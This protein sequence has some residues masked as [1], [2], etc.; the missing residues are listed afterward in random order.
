M[1]AVKGRAAVL[2][3]RAPAVVT[4][5]TPEQVLQRKFNLFCTPPWAGRAGAETVLRLDP[6]RWTACDPACGLGHLV[7]GM[8]D[9]F[10]AVLAHDIRDWG[11]AG[12]DRTD[13]DFL[14]AEASDVQGVD[15]YFGNPPFTLA[16]QFI[17]TGLA[18]A[19]RGVAMLVRLQF[20][21]SEGRY[22]LFHGP[23]NRVA[24]AAPFSE[25]VP[26]NMGR[27]VPDADNPTAYAWFFWLTPAALA[28]S[29]LRPAIEGAWSASSYLEQTI[30]PGTR[31]RLWGE[32][33]VELFGWRSVAPVAVPLF[34]GAAT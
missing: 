21:E 28:T 31:S 32:D 16:E 22:D 6:G 15:W 18:R 10:P 5:D 8:K 1:T 24:M 19:R 23:A 34:E 9:Y 33:D 25:R 2:A 7:H 29:P 3:E 30:P 4:S 14:S 12:A 11:W 26:M 17:R 20:K 13:L 27:W